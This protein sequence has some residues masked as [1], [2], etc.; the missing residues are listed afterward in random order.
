MTEKAIDWARLKAEFPK[1][2]LKTLEAKASGIGKALKYVEPHRYMER[3]DEVFGPE[4]WSVDAEKGTIVESGGKTSVVVN[5]T[6][7]IR[8]AAGSVVR[9]IRCSGGEALRNR[10]EYGFKSAETDAFK[11]ACYYMGLGRYLYN[12]DRNKNVEDLPPAD[13]TASTFAQET[14]KKRAAQK[15]QLWN[16]I[17]ELIK[18]L[19]ISEDT[20]RGALADSYKGKEMGYLKVLQELD[21]ER[22]ASSGN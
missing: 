9:Q 7:T 4:G 3:L 21:K 17:L 12:D 2:Y 18:V 15:K 16:D 10:P 11:R 20:A 13:T 14:E 19:D 1:E 8:D 6:L 5:L 22:K